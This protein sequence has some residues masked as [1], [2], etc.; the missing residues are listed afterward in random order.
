MKIFLHFGILLLALSGANSLGQVYTVLHN[1]GGLYE[2]GYAPLTDLVLSS[3]MLYGTTASGGTNGNGTIFKV[4]TDG[5]GYSIINNFT[6]GAPE[7]GGMVLIGNTLYGTTFTG[8]SG[9]HGTIFKLNA[10][11]SG[12]AVLHNFSATSSSGFLFGTNSDGDRPEGDL[13]TDGSTL[14]GTAEYGGSNGNGTIFKIN[15]NGSGFAVIKTFSATF[16]GTNNVSGNPL[17]SGTNTDGARPIGGLVLSGNTLYGTTYH[18]GI[19]NGVVF[20]VQ[21]DGSNY[22]VLKYFSS[23]KGIGTNSDGAAPVASLALRRDTLYGVAVGGGTGSYGNVFR[24]KTN[25]TD[26]TVLHN[27]SYSDGIFPHNALLINGNTLYGTTAAG[28]LSND[29]TIFMIQTD[30]SNFTILK[31]FNSTDGTDSDSR[32]VLSGRTLYGTAPNGGSHYGGVVFGLTVLPQ[33]LSADESFGIQSNRFGFDVTGISNQTVIVEATTNLNQPDWQPLQT[34]VLTGAPLYFCD[35][36]WNQNGIR[37][38][39]IRSP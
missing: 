18:G 14:Y 22:T 3:N 9:G 1:F 34:N 12:F 21:T 19:S 20:A 7:G 36:N 27:F 4:S 33:V 6:N 13:V 25:G 23:L 32:F 39:R 30:G 15:T 11:G 35:P 16:M 5:S 26:F 31:N 37:F 8:G 38:Y 29:G 17:V 28:G 24:L 2:D 10:S